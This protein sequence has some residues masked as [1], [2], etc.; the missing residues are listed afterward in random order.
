[1]STTYRVVVRLEACVSMTLAV[2]V[3]VHEVDKRG[4]NCL[5]TS[6]LIEAAWYDS[7]F[8]AGFVLLRVTDMV[9]LFRT[10]CY[11]EFLREELLG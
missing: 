2:R 1:M 7:F 8:F 11:N 9:R 3:F 4:V 5:S 10:S 6:V